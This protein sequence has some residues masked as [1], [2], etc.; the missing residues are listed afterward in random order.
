MGDRRRSRGVSWSR[1]R[2]VVDVRAERTAIQFVQDEKLSGR[3]RLGGEGS[4]VALH[5]ARRER[6][7]WSG[8]C[9]GRRRG[10]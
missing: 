6:A 3:I 7:G 1:R 2:R 4:G 9:R 8:R 10:D 5:R